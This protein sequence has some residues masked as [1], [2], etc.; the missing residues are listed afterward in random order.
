M[1]EHA[2]SIP[3][4]QSTPEESAERPRGFRYADIIGLLPEL[5][6][7]FEEQVT[8]WRKFSNGKREEYLKEL[9]PGPEE[10]EITRVI[11]KFSNPK[12][13]TL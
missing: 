13:E 11:R 12:E 3:S 4:P 5:P 2:E 1:T 9:F 8:K 7:D 6:E 10:D